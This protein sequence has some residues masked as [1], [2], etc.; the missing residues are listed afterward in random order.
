MSFESKH[1]RVT[2]W[3]L[4]NQYELR[5]DSNIDAI[6]AM[7]KAIQNNMIDLTTKKGIS[8]VHY[9]N[10]VQEDLDTLCCKYIFG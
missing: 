7:Q 3:T 1:W 10:K 8:V 6:D 4:I 5:Y 2:D 9:V